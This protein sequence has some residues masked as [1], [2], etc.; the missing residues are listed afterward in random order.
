VYTGE[1]KT[2]KSP[3]SKEIVT[4]SDENAIHRQNADAV[5]SSVH[6]LSPH[7]PQQEPEKGVSN[8]VIRGSARHIRRL[9][10]GSDIRVC[11]NCGRKGDRWEMEEHNCKGR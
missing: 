7:I 1:D 11:E 3:S 9:Y 2:A 4:T 6:S 8:S 10:E 5:G